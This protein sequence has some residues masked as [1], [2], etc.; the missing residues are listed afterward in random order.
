MA[1]K[2]AGLDNEPV[3]CYNKNKGEKEMGEFSDVIKESNKP[4]E[5]REFSTGSDFIRF[6]KNHTTI[7][8]VLDKVPFVSWSHFVPKRHVAFP[9]TNAGKGMSFMC[10]GRDICPI[11]EWNKQQTSGG[12]KPKNLLNSRRVYTFNVLDRTPVVNCPSCSSEYYEE[13]Q[14]GFPDECSNPSCGVSLVDVEAAPRNKIQVFQKGIRVVDQFI[15]FEN[16]FGN[17]DSYDIKLD[18]RGSGDSISTVCV[19]KQPVELNLEE[20]IGENWEEKLYNI[21]ELCKP[22]DP[23]RIKR[24]LDGEDFFSVVKDN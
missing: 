5:K 18:T 7:V 13:N 10:P 19:P 12:E 22:M 14:S 2:S 23:E 24:I 16:E 15:S 21:K 17:I 11:C 4:R 6:T 20:I 8:R 9:N 1:G 3:I